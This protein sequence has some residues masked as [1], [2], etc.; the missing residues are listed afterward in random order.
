MSGSIAV[1]IVLAVAVT[2]LGLLRML[3]I[4]L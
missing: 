3:A 2:I 4:A 1:V